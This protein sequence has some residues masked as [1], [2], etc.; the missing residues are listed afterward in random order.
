[1][2]GEGGEAAGTV[3]G[4]DAPPDRRGGSSS[5]SGPTCAISS[6][7]AMRWRTGGCVS[8]TPVTS[9]VFFSGFSM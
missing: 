9:L 7:T 3:P 4:T 8:K 5:A 2:T 1:M 6:S